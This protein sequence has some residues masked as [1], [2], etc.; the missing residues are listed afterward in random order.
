MASSCFFICSSGSGSPC[1]CPTLAQPEA[2][3]AGIALPA[4]PR[5]ELLLSLGVVLFL[6]SYIYATNANMDYV[7][8]FMASHG[9]LRLAPNSTQERLR[10]VSPLCCRFLPWTPRGTC[11]S[12]SGGAPWRALRLG[13]DRFTH[14]WALPLA[15]LSGLLYAL[16][17][18]SFVRTAGMPALGW[19]CLV[20][21]LL[22]LSEV[23]LDGGSCTARSPACCR[24]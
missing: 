6:F 2:V 9:N 13:G 10:R 7:Q 14:I 12:G 3:E 24:P 23:P 5:P 11:T 20:P 17:F 22:C 4:V 8:R 16:A 1:A 18:P 21:L 19:V 15:I